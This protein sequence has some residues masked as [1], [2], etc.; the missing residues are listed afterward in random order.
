MI[1]SPSFFNKGWTNR[2][3]DGL[4]AWEMADGRS[5]I[6]PIWHNVN[7]QD[8][9][10]YSAPLA[11]VVALPSGDGVEKITREL[12]SIIMQGESPLSPSYGK[13]YRD[14]DIDI[15][16]LARENNNLLDGYLFENCKIVGP[17]LIA[18]LHNVGFSSMRFA[19]NQLW[20]MMA[21]RKYI[22]AIGL[23]N[24]KFVNCELDWIGIAGSAD[25]LMPM[26]YL[27]M[28]PERN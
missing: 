22:G 24:C 7:Q 23:T 28:A 27:P 25:D 11:N 3:L 26:Q 10:E 5:R 6:I 21:G 16:K 4:T 9:T 15:A 14:E 8:V 17:A 20:P 13:V 12:V 19:P 18:L 1:L 2:E